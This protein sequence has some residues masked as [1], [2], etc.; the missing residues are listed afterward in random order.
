MHAPHKHMYL[1]FKLTR[2]KAGESDDAIISNFNISL[3][4]EKKSC[5]KVHKVAKKVIPYIEKV[6]PYI[7]KVLALAKHLSISRAIR[8]Q[9]HSDWLFRW[10]SKKKKAHTKR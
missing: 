2:R 9:I 5:L 1:L 6:R 4:S 10:L 3:L 8:D 7:E